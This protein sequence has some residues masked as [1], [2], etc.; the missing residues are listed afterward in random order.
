MAEVLLVDDDSSILLTLSIALRRRGHQVTVA[1]DAQQALNQLGRQKFDF[2]VTDI[3]MPGMS[4]LELASRVGAV[5]SAPRIVLTSAHYDPMLAPNIAAQVAESFL[6][7]PID[8][9]KLHA[10]LS[11][12]I[13]PPTVPRREKPASNRKKQA[14]FFRGAPPLAHAS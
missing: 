8:I 1:C 3:R 14:L 2:V 6:P 10:L 11:Q 7:K 5:K 12:P 4:G 13:S 9:E